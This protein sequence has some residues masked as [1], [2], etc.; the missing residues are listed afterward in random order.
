MLEYEIAIQSSLAWQALRE[1]IIASN[2]P[3]GSEEADQAKHWVSH[4]LSTSTEAMESKW[5]GDRSLNFSQIIP[6]DRN[7]QEAKRRA[8]EKTATDIDLFAVAIENTSK[9]ITPPTAGVT[10]HNVNTIQ[11]LQTG[12]GSTVNISQTFTQENQEALI[13]A[14]ETVRTALEA[15]DRNEH[16]GKEE[17]LAM[18]ADTI[19][20]A[21]K[22][23]LSGLKLASN[24]SVIGQSIATVAALKPA[25]DAVKGVAAFFGVTLP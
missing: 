23:Q 18:V 20:G 3:F 12:A 21:R 9:Q 8:I 1:C 10:I 13:S 6:I 14:L 22:D 11:A 4:K 25:Y 16:S 2:H 24:I 17:V 15:L 5:R 19:D 7:L